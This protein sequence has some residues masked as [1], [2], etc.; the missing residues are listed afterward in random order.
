VTDAILKKTRDVAISA[1]DEWVS[2]TLL[3][4][5][6]LR[7]CAVEDADVGAQRA[8][9]TEVI[10]AMKLVLEELATLSEDVTPESLDSRSAQEVGFD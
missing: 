1:R 5:G 8:H 6:Q 7:A 9:N 3:V 10:T 4:D 2:T